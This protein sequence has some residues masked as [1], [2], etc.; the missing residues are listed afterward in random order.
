M[1]DFAKTKYIHVLFLWLFSF[2]CFQR[3]REFLLFLRARGSLHFTLIWSNLGITA[4]GGC[5]TVLGPGLDFSAFHWHSCWEK[6]WKTWHKPGLDFL[7]GRRKRGRE[8]RVGRRAWS[9][10][11]GD[12]EVPAEMWRLGEE[13]PWWMTVCGS[14]EHSRAR[15]GCYDILCSP[16]SCFYWCVY[17][18]WLV[19]STPGLC[20]GLSFFLPFY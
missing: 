19:C 15:W 3:S 20:V 9:P 4:W 12:P 13:A 11:A 17:V 6:K 10:L 5:M 7:G 18:P 1:L 14:L 2:L 8:S 16:F